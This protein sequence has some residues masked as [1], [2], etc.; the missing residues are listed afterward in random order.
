MG[1][2]KVPEVVA[3]EANYSPS[4]G[5]NCLRLEYERKGPHPPLFPF[6]LEKD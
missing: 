6:L 5:A 1:D 3:S 2:E 4:P